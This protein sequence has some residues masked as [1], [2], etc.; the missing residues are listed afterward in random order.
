MTTQLKAIRRA[1]RGGKK[2]KQDQQERFRNWR[3]ASPKLKHMIGEKKPKRWQKFCEE[4]GHRDPWEVVRWAKDPWRLRT[5]MRRLK[6]KEGK[7]LISEQEKVQGLVQDLFGWD[8]DRQPTTTAQCDDERVEYFGHSEKEVM[9]EQVRK[10]LS[11]TSNSSAPGP[12]GINYKLLKA[13]KDTR[14]GREVLE[15]VATNLIRGSIS[16][17][18]KEMRVVL[19]PKPGRDLTKTQSWRPINLINCIGKLGEKV[20]ADELQEA[21]LLHGGQFGGVKWRSALEGVFKAVTKARRCMGS[22]GNVACGFWDVS[23]G[24]QNVIP[25]QVLEKM[26]KT[27]IGRKWKRWTSEFMKEKTLKSHGME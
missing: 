8:K 26:E 18:W 4:H 19:I 27:R 25:M 20:V 6:M 10:A 15:E 3:A 7:E 11:G 13:I 5:K 14:L 22:G 2:R 17:S 23:G 12:D 1:T 9:I 24:F 16:D 21:D